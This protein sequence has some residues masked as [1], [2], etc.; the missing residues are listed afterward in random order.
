MVSV[1]ALGGVDRGIGGAFGLVRGLFALGLLVIVFNMITP[2]ERAPAWIT[3]AKNGISLASV[4]S[5]IT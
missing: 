2:P 4:P 1:S 3:L 5:G